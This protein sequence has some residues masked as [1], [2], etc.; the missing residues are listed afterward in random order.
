MNIIILII[1]LIIAGFIGRSLFDRKS[2]EKTQDIVDG[3]RNEKNFWYLMKQEINAERVFRVYVST[4]NQRREII[5]GDLVM[6]LYS[7]HEPNPDDLDKNVISK[8]DGI[9]IANSLNDKIKEKE[10]VITD[11]LE[12]N[13]IT[14]SESEIR[15]SFEKLEKYSSD[16][17]EVSKKYDRFMP[18]H[19]DSL[20]KSN[21]TGIS[22]WKKLKEF[23][24][25]EHDF[26][27]DSTGEK[28]VS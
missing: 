28:H 17:V 25:K 27:Y 2:R 20:T 3:I 13:H 18:A 4:K 6:N 15:K 14:F 23:A 10:K 1:V 21:R 19:L 12:G 11:I 9:R 26:E 8:G 5:V 24:D 16:L 22:I 7:K